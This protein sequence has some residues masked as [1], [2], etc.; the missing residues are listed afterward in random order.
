M[1]IIEKAPRHHIGAPKSK[2]F[3]AE[4]LN[5]LAAG[6]YA[7]SDADGE[8]GLGG[9]SSV[10]RLHGDGVACFADDLYN[11]VYIVGGE[12][13]VADAATGSVV[14]AAGAQ[15]HNAVAGIEHAADALALVPL[16]DEGHTEK[17][18][19]EAYSLFVTLDGVSLQCNVVGAENQ[20]V[21]RS[22][23]LAESIFGSVFIIA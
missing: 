23:L 9:K 10:L 17:L 15:L 2:L 13:E 6:T 1:Y 21:H 5:F 16:T 11:S 3:L 22:F 20:I 4:E 18:V 12:S 7:E 19:V 14:I 8:G